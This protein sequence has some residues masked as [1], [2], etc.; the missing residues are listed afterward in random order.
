NFYVRNSDFS[1]VEELRDRIAQHPDDARAR[2]LMAMALIRASQGEEAQKLLDQVEKKRAGAPEVELAA[3]EILI[4]RNSRPAAETP[5]EGMI[6]EGHDGYDARL[7]L[8]KIAV[9]DGNVDEA[10]KQLALAKKY[11]PD[12]AEPYIL[13]AKALMKTDE[14]A[15]A[16]ELEKAA[17]L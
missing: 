15:T 17:E 16:V 7:W 8:G 13:L 11:D 5:L 2:G 1:D 4:A 10:K 6:S 3:A 14:D 12:S 9:D